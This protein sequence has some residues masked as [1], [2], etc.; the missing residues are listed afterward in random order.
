MD[1]PTEIARAFPVGSLGYE[2]AR[3]LLQMQEIQAS[4]PWFL[5]W[6]L[7]GQLRRMER[8]VAELEAVQQAHRLEAVDEVRTWRDEP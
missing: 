1:R 3:L 2:R 8:L 5:R 4:T 7:R 6:T